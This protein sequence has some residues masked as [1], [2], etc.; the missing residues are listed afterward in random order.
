MSPK[1]NLHSKPKD[2]IRNLALK[3]ETAIMKL[4]PT[5]WEVYRKLT[6][7]RISTLIKKTIPKTHTTHTLKRKYSKA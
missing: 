4:P 6:A 7:E 3:V 2:W 1:Y 5:D